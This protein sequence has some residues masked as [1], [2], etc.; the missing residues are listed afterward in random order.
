MQT[1]PVETDFIV[2][3]GTQQEKTSDFRISPFINI[4][5]FVLRGVL[6]ITGT[7]IILGK[8]FSLNAV[9]VFL[10]KSGSQSNSHI[11]SDYFSSFEL[12]QLLK[13]VNSY[14]MSTIYNLSTIISTI[15]Y[16]GTGKSS[17][18]KYYDSDF[19]RS[20]NSRT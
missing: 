13:D 9:N 16:F 18:E 3:Y 10:G 7:A 5:L 17:L 20:K 8:Y 12:K 2:S 14:K 6:C 11:I 15:E 19:I 4:M 1:L